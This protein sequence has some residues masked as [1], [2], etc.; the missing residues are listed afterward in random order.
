M[1]GLVRVSA[2][3]TADSGFRAANPCLR[4]GRTGDGE[5]LL[6]RTAA[7]QKRGHKSALSRRVSARFVARD[8]FAYSNRRIFPELSLR[9]ADAPRWRQAPE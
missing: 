9:N 8:E 2:L 7:R 4:H 1:L 5:A 3:R 6:C